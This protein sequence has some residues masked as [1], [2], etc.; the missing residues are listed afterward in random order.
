MGQGDLDWETTTAEDI[1]PELSTTTE[2]Y[3]H[4]TTLM[5]ETIEEDI[6]RSKGPNNDICHEKINSILKKVLK[7]LQ[8]SQD[9]EMKAYEMVEEMLTEREIEGVTTTEKIPCE[10]HNPTGPL[11]CHCYL[12]DRGECVCACA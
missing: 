11:P 5:D 8:M 3:I 12:E 1:F 9:V 10:G 4:P 7:K 6:K 2:L